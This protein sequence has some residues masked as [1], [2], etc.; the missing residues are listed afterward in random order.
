[1]MARPWQP[2]LHDWQMFYFVTD[3]S[4]LFAYIRNVCV[5]EVYFK[6]SD[7]NNYLFLFLTVIKLG[8][9][10]MLLFRF[11][12]RRQCVLAFNPDRYKSY[13]CVY[14]I[15]HRRHRLCGCFFRLSMYIHDIY[16]NILS[17]S[18][19]F[20][21][22][23]TVDIPV[24][25]YQRY[26]DSCCTYSM[27]NNDRFYCV[28]TEEYNPYDKLFLNKFTRRNTFTKKNVLFHIS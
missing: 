13:L 27:S 11:R 2:L 4:K 9:F 15:N 12:N 22:F 6:V 23:F 3:T 25:R 5:I 8:L 24:L 7:E 1:M 10:L 20:Y 14:C 21:N 18:Q 19:R 28:R 17:L 26:T 16:H